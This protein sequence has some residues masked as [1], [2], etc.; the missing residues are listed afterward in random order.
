MNPITQ[1]LPAESSARGRTARRSAAVVGA[2]ASALV[3]VGSV[4]P[5]SADTPPVHGALVALTGTGSCLGGDGC[6]ALRGLNRDASGNKIK[7]TLA[8]DGRTL[9][10]A[11]GTPFAIAVMV[12]TRQTGKITQLPGR[13]GCISVRRTAGCAW[14]RVS[15]HASFIKISADGRTIGVSHTGAIQQVL[16]TR[17][18]AT[19][20]LAR[21]SGT[22]SPAFGGTC[23]PI[24]GLKVHSGAFALRGQRRLIAGGTGDL[25]IGVAVIRRVHGDWSQVG[26]RDGCITTRGDAGCAKLRCPLPSPSVRKREP[27]FVTA[28]ATA[29]DGRYV[30]VAGGSIGTY[31]TSGGFLATFGTQRDGGLRQVSCTLTSP[32]GRPSVPTWISPLPGTSTV[33]IA[34]TFD[35]TRYDNDPSSYGVRI[36]TAT[37]EADGALPKPQAISSDL[38]LVQGQ[39]T[40]SADGRTLVG[41]DTRAPQSNAIASGDVHVYDI[42]P[43]SVTKLPDPFGTPYRGTRQHGV[44]AYGANDVLRAHDGRFVYLSTASS[45]NYETHATAPTSIRVFG[46][47]P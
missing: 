37:P 6:T 11:G 38:G 36:Y 28:V 31:V 10:A 20:R 18:P 40:L 47:S 19:G 8:G 22:C 32:S 1:D 30:Y 43:T 14:A 44:P 16:F 3:L 35:D 29:T 9:Y 23:I 33:A 42:S 13:R 41:A 2:L 27:F 4:A 26:G 17:N 15:G 39:L 25:D 5:V 7:L 34:Q 21:R 12:R 45:D 24:R 46:V